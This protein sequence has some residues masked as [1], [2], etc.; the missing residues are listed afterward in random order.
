MKIQVVE[1]VL[2]TNDAVA[3]HNRGAHDRRGSPGAEP[4]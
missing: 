1:S 2:K 4:H 3:A